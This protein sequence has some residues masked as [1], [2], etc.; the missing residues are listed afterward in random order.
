MEAYDPATVFSSIDQNGRYAYGN[1]P[2]IALWNISRLAESLLPLI[3]Q[4]TGSQQAA[5]TAATKSLEAFAPQFE[6]AQLAGLRRKLGLFTEQEDDLALAQDLLQRMAANHADFT[7]T[8]RHLCDAAAGA[9]GDAQVRPLFA[10]PASYDVWAGR[11]RRRLADES[12]S[13]PDRVIASQGRVTAMRQANPA[14]I[15]R[16]HR[17]EAAINAAVQRDDFQLFEQM[18]DVV[19]R[20]YDDRPDL[21]R[22]AAPAREDEKVLYTFCG[23]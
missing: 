23:T 22:Y 12:T 15:P 20:P 14:F 11:W 13:S 19:S 3:E 6:A 16:N 5:M 21:D 17:V 4:E 10:E 7:L 9:E 8:F 1:Q 18:L 2:G